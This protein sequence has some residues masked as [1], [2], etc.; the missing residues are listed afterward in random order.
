MKMMW[1]IIN[2]INLPFKTFICLHIHRN[3]RGGHTVILRV[4]ISELYEKATTLF[5]HILFEFFYIMFSLFVYGEK[6]NYFH[7]K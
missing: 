1:N 6:M 3:S 2:N 7:F 4:D 5:L